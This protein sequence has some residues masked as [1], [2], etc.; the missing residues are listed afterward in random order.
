LFPSNWIYDSFA[1]VDTSPV[2]HVHV[3]EEN[4]N[5][6]T[7]NKS[8]RLMVPDMRSFDLNHLAIEPT[9]IPPDA[10]ID[11]DKRE[12]RPQDRSGVVVKFPIKFNRA[13]L[14][15]LVDSAGVPLPL[16]STA[17][18]QATGAIVPIGYDGD[19]F[20]EGLSLHNELLIERPN[21]KHCSVAFE[22]LPAPGDIPLIGPLRCAEKRP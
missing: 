1:V 19:A 20:V 12:I 21:G 22:Y 7:T 11:N 16:G 6:G 17:T 9:D 8:G 18:L 5:V 14:L 2:P 4:R 15:S 10:T 13:A 3:L